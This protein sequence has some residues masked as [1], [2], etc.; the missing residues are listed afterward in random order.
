MQKNVYFVDLDT[1]GKAPKTADVGE[2]K[3]S[4]ICP[5]EFPINSITQ[6]KFRHLLNQMKHKKWTQGNKN[7]VEWGQFY[8]FLLKK[9][10][11]NIPHHALSSSSKLITLVNEFKLQRDETWY[12]FEKPYNRADPPWYFGEVDDNGAENAYPFSY[13]LVPSDH[14]KFS[15]AL[16]KK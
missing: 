9:Y 13:S 4:N 10:H 7:T 2:Y 8:S 6:F 1:A 3:T 14:D 12:A 15:Q 16:L 11:D 5:T